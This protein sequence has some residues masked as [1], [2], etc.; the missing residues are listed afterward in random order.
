M[1]P[2]TVFVLLEYWV[3]DVEIKGVFS[4]E[5]KARE[6]MRV[7]QLNPPR[8]SDFNY[9]AVELDTPGVYNE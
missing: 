4:T 9:H 7:L 3:D 2:T 8:Y 6:A 5:D 1:H